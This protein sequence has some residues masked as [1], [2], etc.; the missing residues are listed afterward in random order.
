PG[1][2]AAP[3]S[4]PPPRK[5][6]PGR[7]AARRLAEGCGA[8]RWRACSPRATIAPRG[9]EEEEEEEDEE[10]DEREV[11][12]PAAA[13]RPQV[14]ARR[15]QP[16]P[17]TGPHPPSRPAPRGAPGASHAR[18]APQ[19]RSAKRDARGGGGGGGGF[20]STTALRCRCTRRCLSA[21]WSE[22]PRCQ[23]T[24]REP[25]KCWIVCY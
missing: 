17:R 6:A 24:R 3:F 1:A 10:E 15:E 21:G 18:A 8:A 12:D 20:V 22:N 25:V 16:G 19:W 5:R 13:D 23:A 9:E 14:P 2:E 4:S 11:A 7:A